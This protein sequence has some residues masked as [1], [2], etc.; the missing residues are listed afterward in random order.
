M[1]RQR[2]SHHRQLK[3]LRVYIREVLDGFSMAGARRFE[4]P[5]GNLRYDAMTTGQTGGHILSDEQAEQDKQKQKTMKAATV[6]VI[7]DDGKVLAVSRRDDPSAFGLPGGKVDPGETLEQ[8]AA[9]E[10]QEETG[11]TATDLRPVFTRRED[12]GF[13]TTTFVG[14]VSGQINTDE[15][16]VIRWVDPEVLFAGP[17]GGYNRKLFAQLGLK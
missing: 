2:V 15:E 4:A 14:K 8:A 12:D 13:T 17:F 11:L 5:P 1:H 16:G 10:L 6:L 3:T 9:R 7:A